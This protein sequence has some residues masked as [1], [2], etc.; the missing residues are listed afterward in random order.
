VKKKYTSTYVMDGEKSSAIGTVDHDQQIDNYVLIVKE[1]ISNS[2]ASIITFY[3][4]FRMSLL[5]YF[6]TEYRILFQLYFNVLLIMLQNITYSWTFF[7]R[8]VIRFSS[9]YHYNFHNSGY[10][11]SSC[12]LFEHGVSET[13]LGLHLQ[14]ERSQLSQIYCATLSPDVELCPEL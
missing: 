5:S 11:L 1:K 9:F 12:V 4:C 7:Q 13:G 6:P 10:N 2:L 8:P 14:V 3:S